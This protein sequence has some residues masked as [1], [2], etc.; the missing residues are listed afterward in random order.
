M[1]APRPARPARGAAGRSGCTRPCRSRTCVRSARPTTSPYLPS[2][3]SGKLVFELYDQLLMAETVGPVFIYHYPTEVSPLARQSLDDP[4]V[5]D[6]FEL[7]I[8]GPGAGQRIQRA[9]RPGRAGR[10]VRGRGGGRR[11]GDAE[12]H[13]ADLAFVRALEYGLPPTSGIGIGIDR[14]DHA[15]RRGARRSATSFSS[16]SCAR[17]QCHDCGTGAARICSGGAAHRG[18]PDGAVD[19][20]PGPFGRVRRPDLHPARGGTGQPGGRGERPA[21]RARRRRRY[22]RRPPTSWPRC[23]TTSASPGCW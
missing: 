3:G 18:D 5:T 10:A 17:R 19:S 20:E 16:R 22:P 6:R 9:Q 21:P 7:V 8:G 15:V 13:P 12:A 4:T 11:R 2:W 23:L 14:L 1:A